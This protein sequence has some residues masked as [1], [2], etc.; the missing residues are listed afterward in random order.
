[1]TDGLCRCGC[2]Q[3]AAIATK[4]RTG[5]RQVAG[6]PLQYA[7]G[8]RNRRAFLTRFWEKVDT[9]GDCW[10]WRGPYDKHGYG[11]IGEGGRQGRNLKA[12]RVAWELMRGPIPDGLFV[13]H[14]CDNPP[15]VNPAHLF[16]GT[17]AANIADR[18]AKGR[19]KQFAAR[20]ELSGRTCLTDAMVLA[21]RAKFRAGAT[22]AQ[23]AEEYAIPRYVVANII[24]R[25]TWK[26][27]P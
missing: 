27:L 10:L 22:R 26:H 9:T 8:H 4:T 6:Q 3:P 24:A 13:C 14:H 25:R 1:M 2:G 12:H 20:G 15:C 5:R 11:A 17:H 21:M 18:V 23:I 19:A 7:P 16:L